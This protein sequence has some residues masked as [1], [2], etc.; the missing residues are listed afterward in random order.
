M[1]RTA[2][3]SKKQT[4]RVACFAGNIHLRCNLI[5]S[6]FVQISISSLI[7]SAFILFVHVS[8]SLAVPASPHSIEI[9]QPD[10]SK[11]KAKIHG[12]EFQKWTEAEGSGHT[13]LQNRDSGY[14]EYAEK[15]PDGI[16]RH[17]GVKV[18]PS[19]LHAPDFIPLGVKP[20]RDRDSEQK[21][22]GSARRKHTM[23]L[24]PPSLASSI[25]PGSSLSPDSV[26]VSAPSSAYSSGPAPGD[27]VPIPESGIKK[28]LLILVSFTDRAIQTSPSDWYTSLFS[29]TPGVKSVANFYKD[30]SF[31]AVAIT[32][33]AHTQPG[34]PAG[35]V[36][37]NI[38]RSHPYNYPDTWS[39]EQAWI[40]AALDAA[41]HYVNFNTLDADSD[42]LIETSEAVV[43]FIVAGYEESGSNKTPNVWAHAW[44]NASGAGKQFPD[45]A[46]NGELNN[47]DMQHPIGII[48]HELG[49]QMLGL[50]DLY[51]TSNINAGMGNF[52]VMAGGCWGFV[53][54]Q[55]YG[56]TPVALDAWSREYLGWTS[57]AVPLVSGLYPLGAALATQ[58]NAVKLIKSSISTTEYWL[59]ENRNPNGWDQGI[60][61]LV[62]GFSGG[63]LVAHID[64][65]AG[66][67]GNNDIN[68]YTAGPHQGVV[69]EQANT[70]TCNMLTSS[71]RGAAST[72][73]FAGNSSAFGASTNPAARYYSGRSSEIELKNISGR[74]SNMTFEIEFAV[75]LPIITAF[76]VPSVSTS[77]EVPIS[78]FSVSG[79]KSVTGYLVSEN[80]STPSVSDSGWSG[81]KPVSY[82]FVTSGSKTLY[83][84]AKDEDNNISVPISAAVLVDYDPST[85]IQ[86]T[87]S[88]QAA[89]NGADSSAIIRAGAKLFSEDLVL[90]RPIDITLDGGFDNA[91]QNKVGFTS[92]VGSLTIVQGTVVIS[93]LI[94]W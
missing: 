22:E 54:G 2:G 17:S 78:T 45:Y 11:F 28:V 31:G 81:T 1:N 3:L 24:V 43:Y 80:P 92:L 76:A 44:V 13:V 19:G 15:Q 40:T 50:P 10:G 38:N 20:D 6:H 75:V 26:P 34:N 67:V 74:G 47:S 58:D 79:A 49:H 12:D 9:L 59:V 94:I 88:L 57:P 61:G 7:F 37:V 85:P 5:N 4:P 33:V 36:N 25:P 56:A 82:R 63:L 89:Y 27:W 52:S 62:S 53:S 71:C 91:Y 18:D 83:A 55:N 68:Q 16:L 48:V 35:V 70:A 21:H 93:D 51:D 72:T 66:T 84:W 23:R 87:T 64:I 41:N 86:T 29:T 30:N 32:P 39:N 14:W 77:L 60:T 46:I 65:S 73:F 69:P 90:N 8:I 42:G